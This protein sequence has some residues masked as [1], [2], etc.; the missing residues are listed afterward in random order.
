[1]LLGTP[2]KKNLGA[3]DVAQV[4]KGFSSIREVPGWILGMAMHACKATAGKSENILGCFQDKR[5]RHKEKQVSIVQLPIYISVN[6]EILIIVSE[7]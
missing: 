6:L 4:V 2:L 5:P 7:L 3:G 1:M